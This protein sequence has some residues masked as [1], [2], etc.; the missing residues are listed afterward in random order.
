MHLNLDSS[1]ANLSLLHVSCLIYIWISGPV[2]SSACASNACDNLFFFLQT[3][4]TFIQALC[5]ISLYLLLQGG[6]TTSNHTLRA[7]N[8]RQHRPPALVIP[9]NAQLPGP[10]PSPGPIASIPQHDLS[11]SFSSPALET[12]NSVNN[13]K[14]IANLV[15]PSSLLV[16]PSY[17]SPLSM[18]PV[19]SPLQHAA[20]H[21]P[22]SNQ[23]P[24]LNSPML[25]PFTSPPFLSS[26]HTSSNIGALTR[27]KIQHALIMLVQVFLSSFSNNLLLDALNPLLNIFHLKEMHLI[28]IDLDN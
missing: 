8:L 25:Q 22:I 19:L 28:V 16:S 2:P 3:E 10:V 7:A 18:P 26:I 17:S 11:A 21:T 20:P 4:F 9:L 13:C 15:T 27:D 5:L 1:P 23:Q 12:A 14:L 24:S 6:I